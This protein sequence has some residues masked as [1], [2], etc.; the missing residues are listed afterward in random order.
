LGEGGR[1]LIGPD[2][3]WDMAM[4]VRQQSVASFMAFAANDAYLAGIGHRTAAIEDSRLLPL[5]EAASESGGPGAISQRSVTRRGYA[6][7]GSRTANFDAT[8]W[9]VSR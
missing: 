4:L 8:F 5:V 7:M 1:F 6:S 3:H 9:H 2:E